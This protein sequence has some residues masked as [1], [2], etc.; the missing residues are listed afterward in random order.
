MSK[1]IANASNE[2]LRV[3]SAEAMNGSKSNITDAK[4]RAPARPRN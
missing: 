3:L 1:W 2:Y 4:K